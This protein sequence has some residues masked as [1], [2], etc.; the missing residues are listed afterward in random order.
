MEQKQIKEL[1]LSG[2][3]GALAFQMGYLH[4]L[5]Q[6]VGV[7]KLREYKIGGISAGSAVGAFFHVKNVLMEGQ[8]KSYLINMKILIKYLL[9][10]FLK[11]QECGQAVT[12]NIQNIE[13]LDITE[14]SNV[15]F[16]IDYWIWDEYWC[17][18]MFAR[19][20]IAAQNDKDRLIKIFI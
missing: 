17:D 6:Y 8:F 4:V 13:Y 15:R 18:E 3:A 11:S 7:E 14:N 20:Q 12:E 19:G 9:M 10:Y 16:P 5:T 2:G 1:L